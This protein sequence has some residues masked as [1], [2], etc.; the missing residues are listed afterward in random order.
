MPVGMTTLAEDRRSEV[1]Q[2]IRELGTP[3]RFDTNQTMFP[4]PFCGVYWITSGLV[5]ITRWGERG[6][7]FIVGWASTGSLVG[8][9]AA[10]AGRLPLAAA[11][12]P[13]DTIRVSKQDFLKLATVSP[14][15][16]R[17]V[18]QLLAVEAED[19]K[20]RLGILGTARAKQRLRH[21]LRAFAGNHASVDIAR[22]LLAESIGVSS[23]HLSRLLG[24]LEAS[25]EISRRGSRILLH[26][27]RAKNSQLSGA[28]QA[29]E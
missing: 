23:E 18:L 5:K 25:G 8:A 24:Q 16:A 26:S 28:Q 21:Q 19:A 13:T 11:V 14:P 20:D 17:G 4:Q 15:F 6:R 9:S 22:H 10:L 27:I 29:L 12:V 7:E 1:A 3:A 2:A